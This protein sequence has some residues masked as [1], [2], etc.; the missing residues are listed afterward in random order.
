MIRRRPARAPAPWRSRVDRALDIIRR[1]D[2][3]PITGA[4][5]TE[6]DEALERSREDRARLQRALGELDAERAARELKEA[7]RA[8]PDPT[9][10]DSATI[11]TL[12]R[13]YESIHALENRLDELDRAV[14]TTVA[15][16][17]ALAAAAV[18]LSFQGPGSEVNLESLLQTLRAD[19]AALA[20]AHDEVAA[21]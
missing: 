13:R 6:I 17:E 9:A 21:L 10:P 2:D 15:D 4:R 18:E 7:L 5:L 16:L 11:L 19:S 14:E 20:S 3:G 8:R 12:R 1:K